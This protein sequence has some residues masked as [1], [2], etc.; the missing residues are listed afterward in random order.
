M[1]LNPKVA[2]LWLM[3]NSRADEVSGLL[4]TTVGTGGVFVTTAPAPYEGTHAYQTTHG[5]NRDK[6]PAAIQTIMKDS[7]KW[8]MDFEGFF[9]T[10]TALA[11]NQTSLAFIPR[12]T[13]KA[14]GAFHL[15]ILEGTTF[16]PFGSRMMFS[17]ANTDYYPGTFAGDSTYMN[18][19]ANAWNRI[20]ITYDGSYYK[21]YFNGTLTQTS[22]SGQANVFAT[23]ALDSNFTT[24]TNF[25]NDYP[26]QTA[27]GIDRFIF[28]TDDSGGAEIAL[29]V[30]PTLTAA[31]PTYGYTLGGETVTL[32]GTLFAAGMTVTIGGTAATNVVIVSDTS[33]TCTAPAHAAGVV[34]IV[35]L[36]TDT[37]TATLT[38][39]YTYVVP[40][41]LNVAP[42]T[43][44]T[45]GGT[46]VTVTGL[47][48]TGTCSVKFGT[49]SATSV[50]LT[51]STSIT[52]LTPRHAAGVVDVEV[53]T[54][55]GYT[56]TLSSGFEYV[57]TIM[58]KQE[59]PF[60]LV[61]DGNEVT[62]YQNN[63]LVNK[64]VVNIF[65]STEIGLDGLTFTL[66]ISLKPLILNVIKKKPVVE[67]LYKDEVLFS[68]TMYKPKLDYDKREMEIEAVSDIQN[69]SKYTAV[70]LTSV[71]QNPCVLIE[72]ILEAYLDGD[73]VT[74]S[75][76]NY[77]GTIPGTVS[78]D[79]D[80]DEI[81]ILGVIGQLLDLITGGVWVHG[82]RVG[83]VGFP[84]NMTELK[85]IDIAAELGILKK[86]VVAYLPEYYADL[87]VLY[88]Y[89]DK[90]SAQF[91]VSAGI[92]SLVKTFSCD[93]PI[94]M[95]ASN[96]QLFADRMLAIFSKEYYTT[97]VTTMNTKLLDIGTYVELED[98]VMLITGK[99][100]TN[101]ITTYTL[102]GVKS[103]D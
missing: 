102:I 61:I 39:G 76:G 46:S 12:G 17:I 79:S 90:A 73:Y 8:S 5:A 38:G 3:N 42:S 7:A 40:Q 44:T 71:A 4:L 33:A 78:I 55:N 96:A 57:K 37:G 77:S 22:A 36:N 98:F 58:R 87:V 45:K 68:G 50:V 1:T 101:G 94:F 80:S 43:G 23:T 47:Y 74:D 49:D 56:A 81:N 91:E 32:T 15:F 103:N 41:T 25:N 82:L 9:P 54:G 67:L 29:T 53:T 83:F 48:F 93:A 26:T 24:C 62:R 28:Y 16:N 31:S 6:F 60:A 63:P 51:G 21:L 65:Q 84:E 85:G 19:T 95:T 75:I 52:C 64:E 72:N 59:N 14:V 100:T 88:Y 99:E 30:S 18:A 10:R 97:E 27:K 89:T 35:I 11:A 34:D 20:T 69:L 92:G 70:M 66:P 2:A 13:G 86:P